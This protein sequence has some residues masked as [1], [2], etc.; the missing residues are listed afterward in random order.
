MFLDRWG[1]TNV[2]TLDGSDDARAE[3]EAYQTKLAAIPESV[4]PRDV[5]GF[6]IFDLALIGVG[7]DG[8]STYGCTAMITAAMSPCSHPFPPRT[9]GP[10]P[11]YTTSWISLS[12]SR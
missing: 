1:L 4:L 7:D 3:A 8:H 5:D 2:I 12:K 11:M 6:P 10:S 9:P